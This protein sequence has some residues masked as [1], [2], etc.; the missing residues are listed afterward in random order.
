MGDPAS[1][2]RLVWGMPVKQR[3]IGGRV[4]GN[5]RLARLVSWTIIVLA[6]L[7]FASLVSLPLATREAAERVD[8]ARPEALPPEPQ[9]PDEREK[10]L[11]PVSDLHAALRLPRV[12]ASLSDEHSRASLAADRAED[13]ETGT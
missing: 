12:D 8:F 5:P 10:P 4:S 11:V 3:G 7:G 1:A 9:T 13:Y 2:E 6:F